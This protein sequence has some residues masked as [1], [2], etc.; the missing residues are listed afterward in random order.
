MSVL[1]TTTTRPF[2]TTLTLAGVLAWHGITVTPM[3]WAMSPHDAQVDAAREA[4][5]IYACLGCGT[6]GGIT[7]GDGEDARRATRE[8]LGLDALECCPD[9]DTIVF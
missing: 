2:A 9:A 4:G 7:P 5:L 1:T 3:A 8:H 6:V